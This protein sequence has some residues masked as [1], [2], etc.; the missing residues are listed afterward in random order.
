MAR[1]LKTLILVIFLNVA[2]FSKPNLANAGECAQ[3]CVTVTR[4]GGE[5]VITARR[6]PVKRKPVA[7][8]SPSSS[9]SP[10]PTHAPFTTTQK[11]VSKRK[12]KSRP[13]LSDQ[14]REVLPSVSFS[15][16]P[17]SGALIWEPLLIHQAGCA[18]V[19]KTLPILDTSITL[20]LQ[21]TIQWSWGDGY[22][23]D[24]RCAWEGRYR[25]PIS[26]W[27]EIPPGIISS[28]RQIVEL[29]R[30]RVFFTE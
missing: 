15:I 17:R 30:A 22:L 18:P 8:A 3:T 24:M 1:T 25:T 11:S 14:I 23:I 9:P 2:L 27:M 16:L 7:S 19:R 28:W 12:A 21:P 20:D 29:F 13:S 26:G 10:S 5:L 6:D 4:E